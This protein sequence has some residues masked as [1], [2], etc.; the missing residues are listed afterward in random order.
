MHPKWPMRLL[1]ITVAALVGCKPVSAGDKP[2]PVDD[3]PPIGAKPRPTGDKPPKVDDIM[4]RF[5]MHRNYDMTRAIE[6]LLV[7][8]NLV[9]AR[10]LATS[11]AEAPDPGGLEAWARQTTAVRKRAAELAQAPGL[12]EACRRAAR[13]AEACAD[14]HVD[15]GAVPVFDEP[16]PL[17]PD[18]DNVAARMARHTWAAERMWEGMIGNADKPWREGVEILAQ[19]PL[20]FPALGSDR[21]AL[22]KRLQQLAGQARQKQSIDTLPERARIYGEILVTCATCHTATSASG[23]H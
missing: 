16:P 17:P 18:Q 5:H 9:D 20:Q 2:P 15:A 22:A 6:R 14:C 3:K 10:A 13:L 23:S 8:G 7:R 11:I 1:L 12:D 21:V 19:A 4:V